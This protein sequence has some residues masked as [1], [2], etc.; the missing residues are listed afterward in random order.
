MPNMSAMNSWSRAWVSV[1]S[2]VSRR[3]LI[4]ESLRLAGRLAFV[5]CQLTLQAGAHDN[6]S[7]EF[8]GFDNFAGFHETRQ[9]TET[10]LTS[11]EL[12]SHIEFKELIVSWNAQSSEGGYLIMDARALNEHAATKY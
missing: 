10:V 5:A 4:G 1:A 6:L 12:H 3:S 7:R 2:T 11:P 9:A 8:L